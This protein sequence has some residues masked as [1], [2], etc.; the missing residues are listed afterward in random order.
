VLLYTELGAK[1]KQRARGRRREWDFKESHLCLVVESDLTLEQ[2]LVAYI[3]GAGAN[4]PGL[5]L[6]LRFLQGSGSWTSIPSAFTNNGPGTC[7]GGIPS[8]S[9]FTKKDILFFGF[10]L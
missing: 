6:I 2:R 3:C 4:G 10:L 7:Y 1:G 8:A 9:A 5:K